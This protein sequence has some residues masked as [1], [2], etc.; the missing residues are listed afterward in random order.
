MTNRFQH[1]TIIVISL[2]Y[3]TIDKIIDE[4]TNEEQQTTV[5]TCE[6][7]Y[8]ICSITDT[9]NHGLYKTHGYGKNNTS[10]Y[11]CHKNIQWLHY[12]IQIKLF[13]ISMRKSI[14]IE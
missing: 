7:A 8:L 2:I 14:E 10:S 6:K 13:L 3:I 9:I 12:N 11:D 4:R 1:S 5:N